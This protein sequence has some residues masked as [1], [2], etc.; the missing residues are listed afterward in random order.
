M[1]GVVVGW[2]WRGY[3]DASETAFLGIQQFDIFFAADMSI[4][5]TH[6]LI[7]LSEYLGSTFT[8]EK[9]ADLLQDLPHPEFSLLGPKS[10]VPAFSHRVILSTLR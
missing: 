2:C 4:T 6:Q 7:R 10:L 3:G 8:G 5:N 1:S 9:L